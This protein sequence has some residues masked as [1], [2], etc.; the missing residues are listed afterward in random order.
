MAYH[1]GGSDVQS[2]VN[3]DGQV[4]ILDLTLIAGNFGTV[5]PTTWAISD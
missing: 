1:L 4:D 2:D 5:G 3:G